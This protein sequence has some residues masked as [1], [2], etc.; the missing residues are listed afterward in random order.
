ML[1]LFLHEKF[2]RHA[3][4]LMVA[5]LHPGYPGRTLVVQVDQD[6]RNASEPEKTVRLRIAAQHQDAMRFPFQHVA[7]LPGGC[8]PGDHVAD[9]PV[10]TVEGET[11]N[12][13]RDPLIRPGPVAHDHN[14][15][16]HG[17]GGRNSSFGRIR[18]VAHN[19]KQYHL[20]AAWASGVLP[21][22]WSRGAS[23]NG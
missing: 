5:G 1:I 23:R 8:L 14:S 10:R 21:N 17:M 20:I 16:L 12:A 9:F 6:R 15:S 11:A 2:R 22:R 19:Y 7:E 3:A 13:S 18:R 4:G